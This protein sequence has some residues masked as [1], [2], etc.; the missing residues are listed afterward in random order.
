MSF[1]GGGGG[2]GGRAGLHLLQFCKEN[3]TTLFSCEASGM[4]QNFPLP[5]IRMST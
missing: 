5:S 3:A 2:G 1:V 4:L